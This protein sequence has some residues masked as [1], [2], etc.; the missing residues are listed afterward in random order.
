M[1]AGPALFVSAR[2]GGRM[3]RS[4]PGWRAGTVHHPRQP[5]E[6]M[7][8]HHPQEK[9]A[10]HV[11][12]D[13]V[14]IAR[15]RQPR[16]LFPRHLYQTAGLLFLLALAFKF[17]D[18]L[19]QTF[20]LAYAAAIL[21]VGLNALQRKVPVERKWFAAAA[22]LFV[23]G[24]V[25]ALLW[26]GLPLLLQQARSV[27]GMGP[28]LEEQLT[29]WER[30]IR[31]NLGIPVD[32]PGPGE[33]RR[34]PAGGGGVM[35][36]AMGLLEVLLFPLV[37]FFGGLFALAKPNDRL[38]TPLMR[39]VPPELRPAFYRIFQLLGERLVGWLKGTAVAMLGVGLLSIVTWSIIGVPNAVLLGLFNGLVEFVPLI[40][41][42]VGGGT[43]TLV[44]FLSDPGK[45]VWV[46]LSALAI[47]Q[48]EANVITPFAMAREAEIHPFLTLFALVLFGGMFGFLG[49][50]LAL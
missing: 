14:A 39:A 2:R 10:P 12:P 42:W 45:A 37:V 8:S 7:A 36:R 24:A 9:A 19:A 41:P 32:L 1:I 31:D 50:L 44:A 13:A 18:T 43:A 22:G 6:I 25:V 21:A 47:Q 26:W 23:V 20:L 30:W 29:K 46:A 33:G 3:V 15:E 4:L 35:G 17:F 16:G 11:S 40:G 27:A 38:L 34:M 28:G 5:S 48:V 49:L